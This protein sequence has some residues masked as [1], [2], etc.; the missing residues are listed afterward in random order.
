MEIVWSDPAIKDLD[1]LHEY[2]ARDSL[3]YADAFVS[4]IFTTVDRLERFPRSGREVPELQDG[5]TREIFV[6]NYRIVYDVSGPVVRILSILNMAR[7]FR[8]PR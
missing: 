6:G 5:V 8:D 7:Q 2:I 3:H 1:A 4:K